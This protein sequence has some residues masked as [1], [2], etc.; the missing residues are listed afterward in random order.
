MPPLDKTKWLTIFC[1]LGEL[2]GQIHHRLPTNPAGLTPKSQPTNPKF[3]L[4]HSFKKKKENRVDPG[5]QWGH[6][7][8]KKIR[9]NYLLPP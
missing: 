4:I 2:K 3:N 1:F 7:S 5:N 9:G 6:F 8:I